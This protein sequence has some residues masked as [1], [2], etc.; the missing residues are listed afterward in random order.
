MTFD[1]YTPTKSFRMEDAISFRTYTAPEMARL[2]N[3][4]GNFEIA[5]T[6]DF[7]YDINQP[8]PVD[9]NT[10]DVVYILRKR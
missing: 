1:I 10:E 6:Y 9:S 7:V 2:I 8:I 5:A 4:V 3:G